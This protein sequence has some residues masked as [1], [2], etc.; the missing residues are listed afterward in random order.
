[1]K[2]FI[3]VLL[4]M[5]LVACNPFKITDPNDPKFDPM[6]FRFEDYKNDDS[7]TAALK[8][9]F[10]VGTEISYVDGILVNSEKANK[11]TSE[12]GD[13]HIVNYVYMS[14]KQVN[15]TFIFDRD[16]KLLNIH[17]YGNKKL[18]QENP[19]FYDLEQSSK[20]GG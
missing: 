9:V 13:Y 5:L 11:N 4:L 10:P 2:K 14:F 16:W 19:G 7:L 18:Y 20:I 8:K 12:R 1:M 6:K 15:H 17:P 3:P